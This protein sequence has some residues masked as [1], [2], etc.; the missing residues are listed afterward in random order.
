[1]SLDHQNAYALSQQRHQSVRGADVYKFAAAREADLLTVVREV[2]AYC[3]LTDAPL[4]CGHRKFMRAYETV[5]VAEAV[6]ASFAEW[7]DD[8]SD[9]SYWVMAPD[10]SRVVSDSG[11]VVDEIPF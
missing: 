8:F 3:P 7:E 1:M 2:P 6:A 10:G 4:P 11:L 9:V 5:E